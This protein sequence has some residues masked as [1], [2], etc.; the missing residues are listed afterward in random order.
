[1]APA[2]YPV[3][4]LALHYQ[5]EVLHPDGRIRVGVAVDDS[6][7]SRVITR[8]ARMLDGARVRGWPIVHVRI[9]FRPDY[10]D[11]PRNTPIFR[12]TVALGAVR[13]GEWGSAFLEALAPQES[14][15]EFVITHARIS[16]FAGTPLE[17]TLHLLGTRH[18]LVAGV[19]THSVVEGTVRDAADRGFSVVVAADAC[20][21]ARQDTHDA[22][23]ASM[24]L[25]ADIAEV[26]SAFTLMEGRT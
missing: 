15:R 10:A 19:A 14:P 24:A 1:M 7:R 22:A 17:Q 13:E 26:D 23:L 11:C 20:A 16:G 25:V 3:A 5:N 8:A 12:Q 6:Q 4:V 2:A 18:L 9:A 21:A